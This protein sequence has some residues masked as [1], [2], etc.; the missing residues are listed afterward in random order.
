MIPETITTPPAY[1]EVADDLGHAA[2]PW[3]LYFA[4]ITKRLGVL[5]EAV[6]GWSN[7]VHPDRLVKISAEGT[8]GETARSETDLNSLWDQRRTVT[9]QTLTAATTAISAPT[10]GQDWV[11][12]L[13]QDATGGRAITWGA[14]ITCASVN[15]DT[16]LSTVSVFHF[17]KSGASWVM[18][19]QPTTGMTV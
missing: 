16:T 18:V 1:T 8:L 19:G 17:V 4:A 7:L 14:G 10:V 9:D 12:I 15:I 5:M 2:R 11:V 3:Y 13:R 6:L